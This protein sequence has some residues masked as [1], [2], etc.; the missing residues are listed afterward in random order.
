MLN[1][2]QRMLNDEGALYIDAP[3]AKPCN[4]FICLFNNQPAS[5]GR[6]GMRRQGGCLKTSI[7][8]FFILV[9]Y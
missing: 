4:N 5:E 9:S 1:I 6:P 8:A 7:F 3:I 2:E